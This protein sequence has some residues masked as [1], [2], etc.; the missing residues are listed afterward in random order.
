M[1]DWRRP[2][3]GTAR[4]KPAIQDVALNV[5]KVAS[6]SSAGAPALGHL[7]TLASCGSPSG[8]QTTP[9]IPF[10]DEHCGWE[11]RPAQKSRFDP[12][13]GERQSERPWKAIAHQLP[14][15]RNTLPETHAELPVLNQ[16]LP[17]R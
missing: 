9:V 16:S 3:L 8:S 2:A 4:P 17:S 5:S 13:R 1:A 10:Q 6:K 14:E 7:P 15:F 12:C 11:N